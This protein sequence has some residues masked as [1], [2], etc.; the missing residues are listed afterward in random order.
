MHINE[1]MIVIAPE[2]K[3]LISK[4]LNDMKKYVNSLF[5]LTDNDGY[6]RNISIDSEKLCDLMIEKS[7]NISD[8]FGFYMYYYFNFNTSTS[9]KY[10]KDEKTISI[11][12]SKCSG[13]TISK[14]GEFGCYSVDF[15][16]LAVILLHEFIHYVQDVLRSEKEGEYDIPS[17]WGGNDK[18]W[19]RP[20]EQQAWASGYLEKL[21]QE[22]KIKKPEKML[23]QLRK[24]G[25]LHDNDLNKL[26]TSDYKS[27]KAIMKNAIALAIA[28]VEDGKPLPW[29]KP[30]N[31]P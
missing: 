11:N 19:K 5:I 4:Y 23:S 26:K 1:G 30:F 17:N 28:D 27:W 12:L 15:K 3:K 9:G 20:W 14:N 22:L 18:Y 6:T 7:K 8:N 2:D 29:Q 13:F 25:V 21:K 24:M 16:K 10:T 31:L